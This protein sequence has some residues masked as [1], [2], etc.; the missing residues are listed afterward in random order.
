MTDESQPERRRLPP[1]TPRRLGDTSDP[2]N[3]QNPMP[4]ASERR[5]ARR[6]VGD[7]R[8]GSSLRRHRTTDAI[9][10]RR[11]RE[12]N[13]TPTTPPTINEP[14][15]DNDSLAPTSNTPL[16]SLRRARTDDS[17]RH[18]P[19]RT[20][21]RDRRASRRPANTRSQAQALVNAIDFRHD[22]SNNFG[23]IPYVS[24]NENDD[25]NDN[26]DGNDSSKSE[27]ESEDPNSSSGSLRLDESPSGS[28]SAKSPM[29]D[30]SERRKGS[31]RLKKLLPAGLRLFSSKSSPKTASNDPAEVDESET[32]YDLDD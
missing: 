18:S 14:A 29:T 32:T 3:N 31:G 20:L 30:E 7:N 16:P 13:P 25:E 10:H 28:S 21:G 17:L 19:V 15:D 22:E 24:N 2:T 4:D 26:D 12:S 6:A 8:G 5:R 23:H 11:S 27:N 1:T 9:S